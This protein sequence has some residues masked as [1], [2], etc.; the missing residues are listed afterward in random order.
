MNLHYKLNTAESLK[1]DAVL[2]LF[3]LA[4]ISKP[5]WS[6]ERLSRAMK[7]SSVIVSA[8]DNDQLIGFGSAISDSAWIG[9]LSQLAVA[10]KYQGLG[11]GKEIVSR[12]TKELGDEVTLLLHSAPE[13]VKFYE[14]VGFEPYTNVFKLQR[15][16]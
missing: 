15:R 14:S 6:E 5:N 10:P 4:G 1:A 2:S 13:A 11:I 12:I 16:K 3:A 8:W 7:G 9:Y